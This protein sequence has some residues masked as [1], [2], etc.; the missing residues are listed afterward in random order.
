MIASKW[1]AAHSWLFGASGCNSQRAGGVARASDPHRR[2]A[3]GGHVARSVRAPS[4]PK[5]AARLNQPVI[6]EN[7]PGANSVIGTA[8]V[9]KASADGYTLLNAS[10]QH[11]MLETAAGQAR[12]RSGHRFHAGSYAVRDGTDSDRARGSRFTAVTELS[13][14]R[15]RNRVS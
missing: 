4:R 11:V 5:L 14:P 8:V 1:I 9:A 6:I 10:V 2:A 3:A 13:P 12:V 7:R 15:K